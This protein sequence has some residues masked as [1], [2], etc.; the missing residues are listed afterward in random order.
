MFGLEIKTF[1]PLIKSK[2]MINALI[3][4]KHPIKGCF[5]FILTLTSDHERSYS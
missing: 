1:E 2:E 4:E 5:S 3:D